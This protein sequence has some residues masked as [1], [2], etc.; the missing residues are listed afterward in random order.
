MEI[1]KKITF[2]LSV[3]GTSYLACE[4]FSQLPRL[5]PTRQCSV[6]DQIKGSKLTRISFPV[7]VESSKITDKGLTEYPEKQNKVLSSLTKISH[8]ASILCV[9]DCTVLPLLTIVLPFVG[10]ATTGTSFGQTKIIHD[11]GHKI[12]NFF[13]LPVG[14]FTSLFNF[15]FSRK[16]YNLSGSLMGLSLIYLANSHGT[17]G[18]IPEQ[19][20]YRVQH[21]GLW[22]RIINTFGCALLLLSNNLAKK[23]KSMNKETS[24]CDHDH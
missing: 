16:I 18:L 15:A 13:V 12:A 9:I 7:W 8:F 14:L 19:I 5:S 10:L 17:V 1:K 2:L 21:C 23:K 20:L 11:L 4:A 22:H 24:C 3:F 6:N